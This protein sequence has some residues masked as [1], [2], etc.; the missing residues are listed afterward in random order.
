MPL[1]PQI[2]LRDLYCTVCNMLLLLLTSL[3]KVHRR[4][5]ARPAVKGMN[6]SVN[7]HHVGARFFQC[8][9]KEILMPQNGR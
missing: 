2:I 7:D 1:V 3:G 5:Q 6:L 8:K 9:E 4:K